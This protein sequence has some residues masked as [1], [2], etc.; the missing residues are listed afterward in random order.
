M[1][2]Y[3]KILFISFFLYFI[4]VRKSV[5]TVK[6]E[7]NGIND[8]KEISFGSSKR[9]DLRYNCNNGYIDMDM[10]RRYFSSLSSIHLPDYTFL[11]SMIVSEI[12]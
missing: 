8:N 4:I 5:R 9:R 12:H 2:T 1:I 6:K 11:S 7:N 10:M 3:H